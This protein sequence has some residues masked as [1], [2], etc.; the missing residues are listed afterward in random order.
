MLSLRKAD[1]TNALHAEKS[2]T[3]TFKP[4]KNSTMKEK[5]KK[6]ENLHMNCVITNRV[7]PLKPDGDLSPQSSRHFTVTF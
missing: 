7:I 2:D 4:S 6:K 3:Q 5:K 1:I